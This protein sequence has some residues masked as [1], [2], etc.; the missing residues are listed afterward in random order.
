M[1][2]FASL[3]CV[4][5][6]MAKR[7]SKTNS[8]SD[9]DLRGEDE[10]QKKKSRRSSQFY[11]EECQEPS[12]HQSLKRLRWGDPTPGAFPAKLISPCRMADFLMSNVT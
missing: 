1:L 5:E 2:Y 11:K 4:E 10:N 3:T 12:M 6:K 9:S 8:D 7:P